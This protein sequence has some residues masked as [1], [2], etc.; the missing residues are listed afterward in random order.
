MK[1]SPT[2]SRRRGWAVRLPLHD[3]PKKKTNSSLLLGGAR[4]ALGIGRLALSGDYA[5]GSSREVAVPSGGP[6][7]SER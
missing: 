5:P 2:I 1:G 6:V 7:T 4:R 3:A